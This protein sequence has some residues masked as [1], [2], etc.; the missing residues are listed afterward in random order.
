MDGKKK[1]RTGRDFHGQRVWEMHDQKEGDCVHWSFNNVLVTRIALAS[2]VC[3]LR[4][5]RYNCVD[6]MIAPTVKIR[7]EKRQ[8]DENEE[9]R[10]WT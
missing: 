10:G 7:K 4:Q 3:G 9:D 8:N 1:T 2:C 6:F 5:V